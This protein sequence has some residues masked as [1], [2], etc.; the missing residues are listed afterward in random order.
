M[1]TFLLIIVN[2]GEISYRTAR[3]ASNAYVWASKLGEEIGD[4]GY[5]DVVRVHFDAHGQSHAEQLDH[6][7]LFARSIGKR[8]V[9]NLYSTCKTCGVRIQLITEDGQWVDEMGYATH[10]E[11]DAEDDPAAWHQPIEM[12]GQ[13]R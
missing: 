12:E 11:E 10:G 13:A 9:M 6:D 8:G 7:E 5:V 4:E 2:Q 3:N 1:E